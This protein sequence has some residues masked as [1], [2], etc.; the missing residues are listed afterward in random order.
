MA[1]CMP[2]RRLS[3]EARDG[4]ALGDLRHLQ[5]A[6][7][8][9][10]A[11]QHARRALAREREVV[12]ALGGRRVRAAPEQVDPLGGRVL[13]AAVLLEDDDLG[14]VL[15]LVVD[16][17]AQLRGLDVLAPARVLAVELHEAQAEVEHEHV[18]AVHGRGRERHLRQ[19][20]VPAP[21]QVQQPWPVLL[22]PHLVE[23]RVH[24][25]LQDL[26]P[27]GKLLWNSCDLCPCT[28]QCSTGPPLR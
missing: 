20:H 5:G 18:A 26:Q 15:A 24:A 23:A 16:C 17:A 10:A 2:W 8:G 13:G 14:Q 3:W 22:W 19:A 11:P 12:A 21:L 4:G 25:A 28:S 6:G 1:Y 9:A 27:C 7:R